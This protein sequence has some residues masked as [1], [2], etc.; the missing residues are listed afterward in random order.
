M[1]AHLFSCY[2]TMLKTFPNFQYAYIMLE[3]M[4]DS[5]MDIVHEVQYTGK[6]SPDLS[7][8]PQYCYRFHMS[9]QLDVV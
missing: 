6:V 2:V 8:W 1:K 9:C 5:C 3:V 4:L 7:R